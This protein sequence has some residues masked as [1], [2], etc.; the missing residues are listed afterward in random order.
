MQLTLGEDQVVGLDEVVKGLAS[1]LGDVRV[2]GGSDQ[3]SKG[4]EEAETNA[5]VLHLDVC[6]CDGMG[7]GYMGKC[8]DGRH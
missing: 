3:A 1:E 2:V 5:L 7:K 6:V 4:G 8:T